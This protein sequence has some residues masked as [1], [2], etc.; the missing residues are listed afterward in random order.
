MNHILNSSSAAAANFRHRMGKGYEENQARLAAL[1]SFG[2][3]LARRAKSTCELSGA[4]GVPLR[5]YEVPPVPKEPSLDRCLMLSDSV[6]EA[7]SKPA[8]LKA[9]DWR[10]LTE[11]IWTDQPLVQLMAI[12]ILQHLAPQAPWC[13]EVIDNAYLDDDVLALAS[14]APLS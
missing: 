6:I 1:S 11:L 7:L 2:K 12:R 14:E 10:H 8:S 4:S 5:I 3:D 9:D 13:Q